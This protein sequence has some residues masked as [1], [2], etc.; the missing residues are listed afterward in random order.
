MTTR[1]T[2]SIR[3][4]GCLFVTCTFVL[5]P[6]QTS[7]QP[8]FSPRPVT[9]P[10]TNGVAFKVSTLGFGVDLA[11]KV[12]P[13]TNIRGSFN[14]F[15][16][17]HTFDE[18]DAIVDAELK[19]RS[20]H[21]NVDWFPFEGGF[22]V[23]PGLLVYSGNR[24]DLQA[25]IRPGQTF[26][27]G[28]DTFL[29]NPTRPVTGD[30]SVRFTKVAPTLMLGWG[31]IIPGG[32]RSWS[33]PFEIGAVFGRAP[34]TSLAFQGSACDVNGRNCRDIATDPMIQSSVAEERDELAGD[35]RILRFYPIVSLG[36]SKRF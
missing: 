32:Q 20:V 19:L 8:R 23:S 18:D 25:A 10:W 12:S 2:R 13:K 5:A 28:D 22:H 1:L 27:L 31:N 17:S 4:V 6:A 26:D 33:I 24:V 14:F 35:L 11:R 9:Q 7:A 34:G 30:A 16:L 15:Q 21:A 36:F 3:T 29:S